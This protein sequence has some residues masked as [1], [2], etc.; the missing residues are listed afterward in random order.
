MHG[1]LEISAD[2]AGNLRA[3]VRDI[4][5]DESDFVSSTGRM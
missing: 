5:L 3:W 1:R 2:S 4:V